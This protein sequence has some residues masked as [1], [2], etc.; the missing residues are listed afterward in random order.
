M[1]VSEYG[2]IHTYDGP[3]IFL[4]SLVM[5]RIESIQLE[6]CFRF[7]I[8]IIFQPMLLPSETL[9]QPLGISFILSC[10]F[11]LEDLSLAPRGCQIV[12]E[13]P[14]LWCVWGGPFY[15]FHF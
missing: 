3:T 11:Q 7:L 10:T 15:F 2:W 12:D 13:P 9:L 1:V 6:P 4:F 8:F 5:G 14:H